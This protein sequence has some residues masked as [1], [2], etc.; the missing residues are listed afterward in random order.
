MR[1]ERCAVWVWYLGGPFAGFQVQP[2]ART[3]QSVLQHALVAAG[4]TDVV[5]PSGRTDKGV[6]A[7]MQ[8][9]S[10]RVPAEVPEEAFAERLRALL[11]KAELG[12]VALHRSAPSFHAQ[13]SAARKEY[14]YRFALGR[15]AP[16]A[17]APFAWQV[18]ASP[19][20]LAEALSRAVGTRDFFA[21]HVKSSVRRERSLQAA[22][23]HE[24]GEGLF[25]AR[26]SGDNFA[27]HQVRYLA[28]AAVDVASGALPEEA[29]GAALDRAEGLRATRAPAEGLVLWE[30]GYPKEVDPFSA[31]ERQS[32]PGLPR[33][34][35]YY[36][37]S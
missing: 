12:I 30:V 15:R 14:R 3:V 23:L 35:P 2:G 10:A 29:Y 9:V 27:R 6:H 24:L 13:W 31:L 7:R 11:P 36:W 25:E 4:S 34:P 19:E 20:K 22:T 37:D 5:M 33:Q 16:A 21:F 28:G 32:A 26:F 18:D 1:V 8:V 17:W